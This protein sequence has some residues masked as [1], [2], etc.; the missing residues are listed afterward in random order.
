MKKQ[1]NLEARL[2]NYLHYNLSCFKRLN[3]KKN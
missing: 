1:D 2:N 3:G